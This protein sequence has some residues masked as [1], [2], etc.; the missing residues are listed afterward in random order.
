MAQYLYRYEA[1]GIQSYVLGTSRL[2]EIAGGSAVVE[3]LEPLRLAG[4]KEDLATHSSQSGWR[5]LLS[6][7]G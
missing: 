1:K 3:G 4:G 2:R 7:G 5:T 6:V